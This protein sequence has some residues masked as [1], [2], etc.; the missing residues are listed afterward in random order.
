MATIYPRKNKDGSITWRVQFRRTGIPYCS[1]SFITEEEAI[2]FSKEEE[3]Y[4]NDYEGFTSIRN[5]LKEKRDR[6]FKR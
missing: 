5:F 1:K 4:V 6:E 2:E 3:D